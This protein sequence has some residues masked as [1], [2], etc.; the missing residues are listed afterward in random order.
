MEMNFDW[1][2]DPTIFKVNRMDAHAHFNYYRSMAELK[3]N[4]SSYQLSL[5]GKWRFHYAKQLDDTIPNFYTK[6]FVDNGWDYIQ[7]PGHIQLQ[8]YGVPTYVNIIYPWSGTEQLVP[9]EIPQQNEVGSYITYFD[10]TDTMKGNDLHLTFHGV[11]SAMAL[12]VN[13]H[14]VGYAEDSF[15]P[16]TFDIT[17][18]VVAGKNKIACQVY[19]Y[20]SGSWLEDQDFWRFSG[21]FRDVVLE[22]IPTCHM[23]DYVVN[24]NLNDTYDK[25]MIK[26]SGSLTS[27]GKLTV[28]LKDSYGHCICEK[29]VEGQQFELQFNIDHPL[30]WSAEVPN[31]YHL[32]FNINGEEYITQRVGIREFKIEDGL[33]KINGK[34]IILHGVDRHD[35]SSI[36]GR[37][38]TYEETLKDIQTMK[39]NN[40]NAVRTSHYPNQDFF[41]DLCDE[42]GL[43]VMDETNLETHGTWYEWYDMDH[44][45][46]DNHVEWHD[47]CVD[48][49]TSICMRDR[50]HPSV[51]L[52]SLGNESHGGKNIYDMANE[53]RRLDNRPIHYEGIQRDRRYEDTSDI[54]S[55]MYT[56]AK[57]IPAHIEAHPDKPRILCEYSHAMGNSNG[58]LFKYVELEKQ[59]PTYQGGFIWD[60]IDQAIYKDG[61]YHYGGDF[62]ERPSDYDF[63]GNGIVFANREPS[64]KM[65]EVRYCYQYVDFKMDEKEIQ[66]TNRYLF[67]NLNE[68]VFEIDLYLEGKRLTSKIEKISCKPGETITIENP[69]SVDIRDGRYSLLAQ[70]FENGQE[71]AKEQFLYPYHHMNVSVS[72]PIKIVQDYLN[73]GIVGD[74]FNVI[75]NKT[76]GLVSYKYKDYEYIRLPLKPNFYRASTN[77][78]EANGYGFRYGKWLQAS[79]Y[80]K[81]KFVKLQQYEDYCLLAFDYLLP[82]IGDEPVHTFYK[83]FGD[84]T[85]EVKM[86]Y[87]PSPECIEMPEF[88]MMLCTYQELDQ[89]NYYGFG[90]EENYIDRN[91]G[92]ML[93]RYHYDVQDNVTPYLYPQECGN[94]TH[95]YEVSV[96]GHD[97]GLDITGDAF[98]F[99]VLPYLPM[100]LE[101][102]KHHEELPQPYQT[103]IRIHEKQMGVAGDDTW[104]AKTHDEFLLS[105]TQPHQLVF[106]F[107]GR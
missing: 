49:A 58:A 47:I 88:G 83:V 76:K 63:C 86:S 60:Y 40:I 32:C 56:F 101:N 42:Y 98:E 5:N 62:R 97:R 57:D 15:T 37:A 61:K 10:M 78:D 16:S 7:V 67:R 74:D 68:F 18:Y 2:K 14:F 64:P 8:G 92:A 21:I 90:P 93:G 20:S 85:I 55:T 24:T 9:G 95:A 36:H 52:W 17:P 81:I 72:K 44:C 102:A 75:F 4:E 41:Y 51:I 48:R 29:E 25:A 59:Y 30:L 3:K 100:E 105:N 31:L 96:Y 53:F 104:G 39:A 13:G 12:W 107:R 87:Q 77:N 50:N 99:S 34:R 35:F 28:S 94:R 22:I 106:R 38:V 23:V 91:K 54:E 69:Y 26:V 73:I 11:E 84:G 43:Y 70:L 6:D 65:Q 27:V 33:M 19:R 46:P 71:V 79:L 45:L 1:I 80:S 103:V 89:V 82:E 66:I